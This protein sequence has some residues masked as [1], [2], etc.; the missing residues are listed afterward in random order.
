LFKNRP[1]KISFKII[2][3]QCLIISKTTY[4]KK[5]EACNLRL[6]VSEGWAITSGWGA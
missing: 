1:G 2:C 4:K 6:T 3:L 5:K